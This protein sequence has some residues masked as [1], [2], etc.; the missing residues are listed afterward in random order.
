MW[1]VDEKDHEIGLAFD[2]D[3]NTQSSFIRVPRKAALETN[4][5]N[6]N[7][8]CTRF[9]TALGNAYNAT[10]CHNNR[11]GTMRVFT[12][13]RYCCMGPQVQRASRGVSDIY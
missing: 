8:E 3:D 5:I 10:R 12:E 13:G 11:G 6:S 7:E 9:C 2:A 1:I 4:K